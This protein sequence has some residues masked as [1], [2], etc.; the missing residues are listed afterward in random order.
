MCDSQSFSECEYNV[1]LK[2]YS[3]FYRAQIHAPISPHLLNYS[4]KRVEGKTMKKKSNVAFIM[5]SVLLLVFAGTLKILEDR[6]HL[7]LYLFNMSSQGIISILV[8][9][10]FI[11]FAVFLSRFLWRLRTNGRID[12]Y[13]Y[14]FLQV[15][16]GFI[17][18]AVLFVSLLMGFITEPRYYVYH[19]PNQQDAIV[20]EEEAFLLAGYG[21]VYVM[22]NA[23]FMKQA[24]DYTT[25]D[26]YRPFMNNDFKLEWGEDE[27]TV[28][29]GFGSMGEQ[30]EV[31]VPL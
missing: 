24:G 26:G 29:Y 7:T 28:I 30:K 6:W 16:G 8:V 14:C 17:V 23:F 12:K 19:S 21:N 9:I 20:I 11:C 13:L 5:L 15:S 22:E 2:T 3:F 18:L 27:V 31:V 25:D 1:F 10:S 4:N